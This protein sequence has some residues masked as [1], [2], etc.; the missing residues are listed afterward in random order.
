MAYTLIWSPSARLDLRELHAYIAEDNPSA[1]RKFVLSVFG[2]I[3]RLP[4]FPQS[5]RVV[6]EFGIPELREVIHRPCR[7]VYRIADK[8]QTIEIVRVWHSSRGVPE[9]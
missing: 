4:T 1:A 8:E 3:E 5:G 2:A 6:P 9:I 7:V